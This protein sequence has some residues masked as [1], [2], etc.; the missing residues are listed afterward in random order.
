MIFYH[1]SLH[2]SNINSNKL[3]NI[4]Y[5]NTKTGHHQ[6]HYPQPILKARKAV[7]LNKNTK[8]RQSTL[9]LAPSKGNSL[10]IQLQ[11]KPVDISL[12]WNIRNKNM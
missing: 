4:H 11:A 9:L 6:I 10:S 2:N 8:K 1:S 5:P 12:Q 7:K 3:Q